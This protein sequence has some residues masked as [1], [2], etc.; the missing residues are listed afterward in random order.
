MLDFNESAQTAEDVMN[1]PGYRDCMPMRILPLSHDRHTSKNGE[2]MEGHL[3][4]IT[5]RYI[6]FSVILNTIA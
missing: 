6:I 4:H 1:A 2:N 5:L 3:E